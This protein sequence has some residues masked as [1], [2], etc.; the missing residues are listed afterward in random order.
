MRVVLD[1][2]CLIMAISARNKYYQVWQD[3]QNGKSS[4]KTMVMTMPKITCKGKPTL[5]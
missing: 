4:G 5:M 2:N 3:L 1:T